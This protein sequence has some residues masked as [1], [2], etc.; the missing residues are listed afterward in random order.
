MLVLAAAAAVMATMAPD[1]EAGNRHQDNY[2]KKAQLELTSPEEANVIANSLANHYTECHARGTVLTPA[3]LTKACNDF[4]RVQRFS[5]R[6][7]WEN[8]HDAQGREVDW[9]S[10]AKWLGLK[11]WLDN[12]LANQ[13]RLIEQKHQNIRPHTGTPFQAEEGNNIYVPVPPCMRDAP[14]SA[15][16]IQKQPVQKQKPTQSQFQWFYM[17]QGGT[18][19]QAAQYHNTSVAMLQ[20]WNKISDPDKVEAG[21]ALWVIPGVK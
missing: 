8:P 21:R 10:I 12:Y 7:L 18:L 20:F 16:V 14:A 15:H 11:D 1:A 19:S 3:G 13:A 5:S 6:G 17:P 4:K 2:N 9:T